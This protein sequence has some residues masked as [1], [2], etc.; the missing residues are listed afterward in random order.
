MSLMNG[1]TLCLLVATAERRTQL[2]QARCMALTV[3]SV[4]RSSVYW[5]Y[6]FL[7][8]VIIH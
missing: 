6:R 4:S 3:A 1:R 5:F 7:F 8:G 2:T